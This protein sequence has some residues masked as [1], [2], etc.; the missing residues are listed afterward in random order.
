MK[1]YFKFLSRNKAYAAIDVFGLA[2]SMMFVVLIG[3]YTWQENHVD[4]Q[5]SKADRMY[6][7]GL[8]FDGNKVS[9]A[10]WYLQFLLKDKFPEIES[11]TGIYRNSRWLDY[12]GKK[13]ATECFFVD[14]TFYDIFDFKL[15]QGDRATSLDNPSGIIV[16]QEYARRVWGDEDPMGKSIVF[17]IEE[18]P[19]VVTGVMEPMKNTA[20][21]T[22]DR[23]PVDMLL[24]FSMMKYVNG[25]LVN[26]NMANATGS[27]LLLLA[28]EGYD[29]TL[30]KKEYE[31]AVKNDFWILNL[32]E[33]GIHLDVFPFNGSYFSDIS[34]WHVNS[35]NKKM[36]KMLFSVGLIILLFAIM[37]YINLTVALAGK[38]AKEM[39]TRRLLGEDRV[40]IMWRLIAE[41]T[42]LCGFSMLLGIGL[43]FLM[44][45]YASALIHSPIDIDGCV[46]LTTIIFL[47][48]ILLIMSLASGIIP[49]LQLSSMKPI[50]AAKGAFQKKSNMMF[51]K[52]F[53]V[54][55]N[56]A[57]IVMIACAL[58]MYL[59]VRHMINA[60]LG[61]NPEGIISIPFQ[62]TEKRQQDAE[63][64]RE[65]LLKLSCVNKVS[66]SMGEPHNRGNNNT[67]TYEGKTISFQEFVVDSA[68]MDLFGLKLKKE[69]NLASV[70]KHYINSQAINELGID[71]NAAEYPAFGS[72]IP[73]AGI[74]EDFK[75]GNVL[76]DQHPVRI[77]TANPFADNYFIPWDINIKTTG[78]RQQ[79]L[80]QVKEVFEKVYSKEV[81]DSVFETPF[82]SQQIEKDFEYQKRLSTILTIFAI[83]AI[84]ISVLGLIAISTYYVRQRSL[85][86]AVHKV[87]GATSMEVL[88]QLVRPFMT[89]VLIAAVLS[90]P[91][92]YYIM[93]DWLSQFSYRISIYWWIYASV[94]LLAIIICLASVVIQAR[95]AANTNPINSLK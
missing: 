6:W 68:F 81:S 88:S 89:Y 2:V 71:E 79:A 87:M 66:F 21:M 23:K 7:L 50:E 86:I 58:T 45:P 55:Q 75:I 17:N 85:D 27:A 34:S 36:L 56:V 19:F 15:I 83:I 1:S 10:H 48:I 65:E 51:G 80:D 38:R 31:E 24:N 12:E 52:I 30:R 60:P 20:L 63:L 62:Y 32:P 54:I 92:I 64:F 78:D 93:N 33:G 94:S 84:M 53:I 47:I 39:A 41:S 59:Q 14:S 46:N 57:T 67:F 42:I 37:N 11:A 3:C 69:N 8:D 26:P 73:I 13:I 44:Q 5:H 82:L 90:I 25:S 95:K 16:T 40:Q 91:I 70:Y 9:G 43:A 74:L 76:T 35:G 18:D 61:Y 28:K 77:I 4:R 22:E 49:A 72:M 29:L